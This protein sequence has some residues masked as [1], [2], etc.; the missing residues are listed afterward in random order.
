[1]FAK[2]GAIL[3]LGAKTGWGG[4]DNPNELHLHL[5][6]GADNTFTLYEDDGDSRGYQANDFALTTITQRWSDNQL[7]LTVNAA[8]GSAA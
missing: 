8:E 3:P 7:A 5:F 1:M 2:A 6:A 4:I